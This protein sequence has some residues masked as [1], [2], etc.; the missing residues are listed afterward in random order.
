MTNTPYEQMLSEASRLKSECERLKEVNGKLV[1]ALKDVLD[2][3]LHCKPSQTMDKMKTSVREA[4][5]QA[6]RIN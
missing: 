6:E 4:L 1:E 3:T 5:K 2:A